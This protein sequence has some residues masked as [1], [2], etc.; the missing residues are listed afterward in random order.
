MPPRLRTLTPRTNPPSPAS[1]RAAPPPPPPPPLPAAVEVFRRCSNCDK[2]I[3]SQNFE[4]H[5]MHCCRRFRK[6]EHCGL[7]LEISA[8]DAHHE[9]MRGDITVLRVLL[10]LDEL[11]SNG[12]WGGVD[13]P[14]FHNVGRRVSCSRV[15][16]CCRRS[17][18][19]GGG[20]GHRCACCH[21][22]ACGCCDNCSICSIQIV[23]SPAAVAEG[24]MQSV[25]S[26]FSVV[27]RAWAAT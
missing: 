22:C 4:M 14:T 25:A 7:L 13:L 18:G 11:R 19:G 5:E 21:R 6:C 27:S 23:A 26:R 1:S 3:L 24:P 9:E 10:R 16:C 8:I 20:D 12:V 17:G 2:D 15:G